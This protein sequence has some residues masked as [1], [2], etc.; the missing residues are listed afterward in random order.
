MVTGVGRGIG[1]AV[2]EALAAAGATMKARAGL[3]EGMSRWP[4]QRLRRGSACD[5]CQLAMDM[6]R[7]TVAG[8]S[9]SLSMQLARSAREIV[10]P[11]GRLRS[12]AVR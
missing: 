10:N 8:S 11:C 2:A 3:G 9:S 4:A 7:C 6:C 5:G 1:A 12:I